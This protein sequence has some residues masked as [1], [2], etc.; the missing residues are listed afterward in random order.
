[1]LL[2]FLG[3]A[4]G[5]RGR[6]RRGNVMFEA[7]VIPKAQAEGRRV[8]CRVPSGAAPP[9]QPPPADP[10]HR[11]RPERVVQQRG[12]ADSPSAAPR[13]AGSGT[14]YCTTVRTG[15]TPTAAPPR[16]GSEAPESTPPGRTMMVWVSP[17]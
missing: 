6:L 9:E 14:G 3:S 13:S 11:S 15:V 10:Q 8:L 5:G 7:S 16:R 1:M 4:Q 17:W 2:Q 12:A